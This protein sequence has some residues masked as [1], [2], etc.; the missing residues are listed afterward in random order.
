MMAQRG[1]R[2]KVPPRS[3]RV[4]PLALLRE[5]HAQVAASDGRLR[6]EADSVLEVLDRLGRLALPKEHR[7]QVR[8]P[9]GIVR[10]ETDDLAVMVDRLRELALNR[11]LVADLAVS[12]GRVGICGNGVRPECGGVMPDLDL[13][14]GEYPERDDNY[15]GSNYC[16]SN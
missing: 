14:P 7:A 5:R 13:L 6:L 10:L 4:D 15:C 1:R 12:D 11:H 3:P 9:F 16:G 2:P 8:F